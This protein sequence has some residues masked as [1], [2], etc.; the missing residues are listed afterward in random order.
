MRHTRLLQYVDAVARTG[1]MR[2]AAIRLNVTPS[3]LN[4]RIQDLEQELGV[5]IFERIGRGVRLTTAGDLF[6]RH[7]RGQMAD[8][9]RVRS[10]IND[11]IGL[12]RGH[13]SIA[14]S[15]AAANAFLP[16]EISRYR[17]L[18]PLVSFKVRV[19]AH[20]E[21]LQ[22]LMDY[23]A[24]MA[25]VFNNQS[26]K[27]PQEILPTITVP[28]PLVAIMARSHPLAGSQ[29]LVRLQDCA[30]Y[31]LALATTDFGG[32]Q[33]VEQAIMLMRPK[34]SM[35]LETNSF[36]MMRGYVQHEHAIMFQVSIGA[37]DMLLGN[38]TLTFRPIDE[39]DIAPGYLTLSQLRDR[40]LPVAS[41]K[42][43]RQ[44]AES[45]GELSNPMV[46]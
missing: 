21:A 25:L 39:Q 45:L 27:P 20:A 46:R 2:A 9:D 6:I 7:A 31:P 8:L 32:R 40:A 33:M 23:S 16:R 37:M 14:C 22:V 11:L 29:Q 13:I 19:C 36:E 44:L 1:S 12:R 24:D 18:Y 3:A 41:A 34:P 38:E 43:H 30:R 42:F 28:Q 5:Q 4:R 15:Q 35:V 26:T 10:L 17:K